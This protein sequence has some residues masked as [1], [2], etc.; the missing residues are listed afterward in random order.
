MPWLTISPGQV[1]TPAATYRD[2]LAR[3]ARTIATPEGHAVDYNGS[4]AVIG[5][6]LVNVRFLLQRDSALTVTIPP[7]RVIVGLRAEAAGSGTRRAFFD[8][9]LMACELQGCYTG[10]RATA[11]SELDRSDATF[12]DLRLDGSSVTWTSRGMPKRATVN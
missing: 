5:I 1:A 3:G 7:D 8:F 9:R 4:G 11:P 10:Q 2:H 12:E 6:V